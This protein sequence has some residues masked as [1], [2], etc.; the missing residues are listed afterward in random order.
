MDLLCL[1]LPENVSDL[2]KSPS[3]YSK[4]LFGY[5]QIIHFSL[6]YPEKIK[7][8]S[9]CITIDNFPITNKR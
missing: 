7:F 5:K 9:N 8:F 4:Q 1:V 2:C 6:L 3:F